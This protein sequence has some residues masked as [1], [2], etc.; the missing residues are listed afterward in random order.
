MRN[1]GL[2]NRAVW[3]QFT[4]VFSLKSHLKPG[5]T[6]SISSFI[7]SHT[8]LMIFSYR[9]EKVCLGWKNSNPLLAQNQ[10]KKSRVSHFNDTK[11][12]VIIGRCMNIIQRFV[13]FFNE[14]M[15]KSVAYIDNKA[16]PTSILCDDPVTQPMS[17]L[18]II[19]EHMHKQEICMVLPHQTLPRQIVSFPG[20]RLLYLSC[21][22]YSTLLIS[23]RSNQSIKFT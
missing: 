11:I 21:Y 6:L 12:R 8:S 13:W 2:L 7:L 9:F 5:H 19:V 1:K 16:Q 23:H 14:K 15:A 17:R 10:T 18:T 3:Q 4:V 22:C 20:H